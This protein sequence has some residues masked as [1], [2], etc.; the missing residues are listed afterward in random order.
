MVPEGKTRYTAIYS[1]PSANPFK[2]KGPE[3]FSRTADVDATIPV[4]Q[5]ETFARE[6]QGG[7]VFI[8]LE[9]VQ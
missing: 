1:R 6:A 2:G 9:V 8:R 5:V 4:E 7:L 3:L